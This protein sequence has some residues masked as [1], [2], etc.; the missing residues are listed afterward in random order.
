MGALRTMLDLAVN[1]AYHLAPFS[2]DIG[3]GAMRVILF[4]L[5]CVVGLL[6]TVGLLVVLG[7]VGLGLLVSQLEPWQKVDETV[8]ETTVLTLDL[9]RGVV[10]A[11]PDNPL[12]R[13]SLE[14]ALVIR[15]SLIAL[16]R[17]GDDPKV[18]G[19]VA[20]VG[21][22]AFGLAQVQEI[23]DA[24]KRFRDKGK[25][26]VAFAETFGEGGNGTL[27]FYLSSAFD[28]V[29]LQPSGN[30]D[31]TG[32]LLESPFLREALDEIGVEPQLSQRDEYK[33]AM[34][35]FTDT[36]L[37]APQRENLT[38]L[39]DSWLGQ[40][41]D[42]VAAGRD[43][44]ADAVRRLIDKGPY[45]STDAKAAG[46]V[47]ELGYWDQVHDA[48]HEQAG[49]NA[50]FLALHRY[51]NLLPDSEPN[52]PT[53]ALIYGLGPVKLA[54]SEYDPVFGDVVMGSST[55]SRAIAGALEDPDVKAILFRVD[56]PGGSYVASDVIW[57]QVQLARNQGMPLVVSMG[58]VAASGGY[59]VAAS[60]HKI[61]AQPATVT[62][63]I[64]VVAGKLVLTGLWDKL[65]I[66]WDGV[67]AGDNAT[68]W[69]ANHP[70]TPE[71]WAHLER[72]LDLTYEDFTTKVA[73]GRGLTLGD[74]DKA[75]K[76]QVWTGQDAVDMGLVDELGGFHRAVELAGELAGAAPGEAV[77]LK[78]FPEER[79][80][81]EAVFQDLLG[82]W[83]SAP[84]LRALARA[85]RALLPLV[86]LSERLTAEPGGQSLRA[87][88]LSIAQ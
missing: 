65:G 1:P 61:I 53:V 3:D 15:D 73:E 79:D 64:G 69:S 48:V 74:V 33:G 17:A 56:S 29:W 42:G 22:G 24:V 72:Q 4:I 45:D 10:E 55:V 28:T 62:G 5:K 44:D 59:F 76:G 34:N 81:F 8:P 70:F 38:Q 83:A 23:R 67:Q 78:R 32:L 2:P 87:P 88:E 66:H 63:S 26:A 54:K 31:L 80:P 19:L 57:R 84:T 43:L 47:D 30:L 35:M 40:I 60:A 36:K 16:D 37:P 9:R 11:L 49:I 12:S 14:D 85:A 20:R 51:R 7:M 39:V 13:V 86:E 46:L 82:S 41:A 21:Q 77:K 50:E 18:K 25:F 6:A 27:H 71:E 68:I 58:D 75:A 52:G